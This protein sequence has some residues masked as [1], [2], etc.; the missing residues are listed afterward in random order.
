MIL[1]MTE[2]NV[3]E[4]N[5]ER[6]SKEWVNAIDCGGLWHVNDETYNIF[7]LTLEVPMG[8]NRPEL[9]IFNLI[10]STLLALT[11]HNFKTFPHFL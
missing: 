3:D 5:E 10:T 2:L 7:Y 4:W 8:S 11:C 9:S 6:G 1:F